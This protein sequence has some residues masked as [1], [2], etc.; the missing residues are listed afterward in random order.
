MKIWSLGRNLMYDGRRKTG[1]ENGLKRKTSEIQ[2]Q[3]TKSPGRISFVIEGK[4][5]CGRRGGNTLNRDSC[6]SLYLSDTQRHLCVLS[7]FKAQLKA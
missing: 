6:C 4:M 1:Q 5:Q 2:F 7:T 3:R